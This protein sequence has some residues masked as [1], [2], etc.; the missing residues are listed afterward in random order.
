MIVK[1]S[2]FLLQVKDDLG[3]LKFNQLLQAFGKYVIDGDYDSCSETLFNLY[4]GDHLFDLIKALTILTNF[5]KPE[6]RASFEKAVRR[7]FQAVK[8]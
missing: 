5:L 7:K 2:M 4:A 3:S 8:I 1:K 6:H